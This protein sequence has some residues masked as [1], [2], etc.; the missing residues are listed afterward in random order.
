[1]TRLNVMDDAMSRIGPPLRPAALRSSHAST[2]SLFDAGLLAPPLQPVA[3]S[4]AAIGLDAAICVAMPFLAALL[5][6]AAPAAAQVGRLALLLLVLTLGGAALLGAYRQPVLF[7]RREQ[8]RAVL[9]AGGAALAVCALAVALLADTAAP[10]LSWAGSAAALLLLGLALGRL[11]VA[12]AMAGDA[13]RRFAPRS[14]LVGSGLAGTRLARLLRQLDQRAV[15]VVGIV[16]DRADVAAGWPDGVT[17]LGAVAQLP[18]LVRRGLIDEVVLALPWAEAG[19]IAGLID[20]LRDYPV[21]VRLAPDL[22]GERAAP[23]GQPILQIVERPI[24]GWRSVLKRAEDLLVG[25]IALLLCALPMA[26]IALA[27]RLDSPGPVLFRQQ[28]TGFNNRDFEMLKFRTMH[29]HMAEYSIRRQTTRND[30]RVT[31]VG[32]FLR[33][34]SL[35]ELPQIFNVLRGDMAIVGPRPHAPGTRAG[36]R[37]FEQ[38]VDRYAAR[39]RVRPG[40]TGLAQVRGHRGET[41]TEDKLIRRVESDLEYIDQWSLWLD[42]SIMLRTLIIVLRMQNAY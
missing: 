33:R 17:R 20:L 34:S 36:N 9:L 28:R 27:V 3:A 30:P 1:M 4:L 39:H 18:E 11:V 37:P 32:A 14:V 31:R 41:R 23:C 19:R 13:G 21:R 35:D 10:A 25:G 38:V 8:L 42:L 16:D 5:A 12:R 29:H 15:R 2:A 40:L 22:V 24:A 26:L 7:R 6:P